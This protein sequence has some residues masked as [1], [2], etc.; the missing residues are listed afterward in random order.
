MLQTVCPKTSVSE[1][2]L[3]DDL[4][5]NDV[6]EDVVLDLVIQNVHPDDRER[7][8]GLGTRYAGLNVTI[9]SRSDLPESGDIR[10]A[11]P[12]QRRA[13]KLRTGERS[14]RPAGLRRQATMPP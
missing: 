7:G 14:I 3:A 4:A 6:A 2:D 13:S 11:L 5:R 10:F 8:F 9:G 12:A 1:L